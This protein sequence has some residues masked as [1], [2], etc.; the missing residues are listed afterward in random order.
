MMEMHNWL[1][2]RLLPTSNQIKNIWRK[3][4]FTV[5]GKQ[6]L[7]A[8]NGRQTGSGFANVANGVSTQNVT[9]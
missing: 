7:P 8:I 9:A 6:M 3:C 1:R 4:C 2:L 5:L